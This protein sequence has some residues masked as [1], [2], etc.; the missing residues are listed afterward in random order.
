MNDKITTFL[1]NLQ[2][3]YDSLAENF[4]TQYNAEMCKAIAKTI[5]K[6]PISI[7]EMEIIKEQC[8]TKY[9]SAIELMKSPN[10]PV[11]IKEH[12]VD[13]IIN[14][15]IEG[16]GNYTLRQLI[17]NTLKHYPDISTTNIKYLFGLYFEQSLFM[18]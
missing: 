16:L 2:N 4:A 10:T 18:M 14:N 17:D 11:H 5:N 1:N 9:H 6:D 13:N 8:C 3:C 7:K 12:I 15:K